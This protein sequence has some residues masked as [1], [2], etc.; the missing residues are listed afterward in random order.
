MGLQSTQDKNLLLT[1][2]MMSH[3]MMKVK[4]PY[5]ELERVVL[6]CLEIAADLI[7]GGEKEVNKINQIPLSDITV[8]RRCAVISADI[9][10]IINSESIKN[11][12]FWH[13]TG[14]KH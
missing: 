14:R 13:T 11:L 4:H 3:H 6:P 9:K 7:H 10:K 5:T 12:L 1:S 8:A 2:L